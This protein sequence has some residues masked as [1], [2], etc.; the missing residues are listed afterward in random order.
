MAPEVLKYIRQLLGLNQSELAKKVGVSTPS[1]CRYETNLI[2]MNAST[3]LKILQV[4]SDAGIS[5]QD[6]IQIQAIFNR[7]KGETAKNG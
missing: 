1:I 2:K 3:E 4:F 7:R 5:T 6:V